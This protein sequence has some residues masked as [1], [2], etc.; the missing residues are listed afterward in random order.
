MSIGQSIRIRHMHSEDC[1]KATMGRNSSQIK[2]FSENSGIGEGGKVIE[3]S[4]MDFR[5]E[6]QS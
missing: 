4:Y 5:E 2:Y 3:L 1:H 6:G